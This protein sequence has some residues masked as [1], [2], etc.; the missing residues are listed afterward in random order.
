[1]THQKTNDTQQQDIGG[2]VAGT[3][4]HTDKGLVPI[5]Q[6]K[7]GDRVLSKPENGEGEVAY[8]PVVNTFEFEDKEIW[9]VEFRNSPC[10]ED[11]RIYSGEIPYYHEFIVGTPNHPFWVVGKLDTSKGTS[12][13]KI[14]FPPKPY[15]CRLD[16]LTIDTIVLLANNIVSIVESIQPVSVMPNPQYGF[17]Q[18]HSQYQWWKEDSGSYIEFS[19]H[20]PVLH[21]QEYNTLFNEDARFYPNDGEWDFPI[22]TRKVF[23]LEPIDSL[24]YFVGEGGI[25]VQAM[26][27]S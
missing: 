1:M 11:E 15:W 25:W 20:I 14:K 22:K 3:L 26:T 12:N 8:K 23:N 24:T 16:Q 18:G 21:N 2:F 27:S 19:E 4:V 17:I 10:Y 7:V 5:E 13:A 9:F 6:I